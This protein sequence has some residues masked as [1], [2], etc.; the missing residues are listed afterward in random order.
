MEWAET[1]SKAGYCVEMYDD[2][3]KYPNGTQDENYYC[4][5]VQFG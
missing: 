1:I 2:A 5:Y 4:R 3:S